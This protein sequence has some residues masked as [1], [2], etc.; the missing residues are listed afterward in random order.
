MFN[1]VQWSSCSTTVIPDDA[2]CSVG[3]LMERQEPASQFA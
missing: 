2:I 1:R 3:D